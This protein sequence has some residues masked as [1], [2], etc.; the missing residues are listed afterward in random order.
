[1]AA[2]LSASSKSSA[3]DYY[4]CTGDLDLISELLPDLAGFDGLSAAH[5][6]SS[7][8]KNASTLVDTSARPIIGPQAELDSMAFLQDTPEKIDSYAPTASGNI[9]EAARNPNP[10]PRASPYQVL[11]QNLE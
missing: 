1:M 7:K 11:L 6:S 5:S 10:A 3:H 4:A 8:G 2:S 9:Y